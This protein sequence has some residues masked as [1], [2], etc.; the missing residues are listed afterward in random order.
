SGGMPR[1]RPINWPVRTQAHWLGCWAVLLLRWRWSPTSRRAGSTGWPEWPG[2]SGAG[3][4]AP[5]VGGPRQ[6]GGRLFGRARRGPGSGPSS[7]GSPCDRSNG[8]GTRSLGEPGG[9]MSQDLSIYDEERIVLLMYQGCLIK[10]K[11]R[12]IG[13]AHQ[14][15]NAEDA[16]DAVE[17]A[18]LDQER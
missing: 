10:A 1:R 16:G 17:V 8:S 4:G 18:R 7:G 11:S 6:R 13:L 14:R 2:A 9:A 12:L 15:D 3:R 5:P